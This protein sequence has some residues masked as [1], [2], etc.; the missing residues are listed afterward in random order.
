MNHEWES[1]TNTNHVEFQ[2]EKFTIHFISSTM[3]LKEP[4]LCIKPWMLTICFPLFGL[5]SN[6]GLKWILARLSLHF[7][8]SSLIFLFTRFKIANVKHIWYAFKLHCCS[9]A[10][11]IFSYISFG[12]RYQLLLLSEI[13]LLSLFCTSSISPMS[14]SCA[15]P[16]S[17]IQSSSPVCILS[18]SLL[19]SSSSVCM[20]FIS[21]LCLSSSV[22]MFSMS[23][24]CLSS[25]VYL[26]PISEI[27]LSYLYS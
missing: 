5:G 18:M 25:S 13:Y 12:R 11:I 6:S 4:K 15:S 8:V 14:S 27:G 1:G 9:T 10:L 24:A 3:P 16:M 7:W 22:C 20:M 26:L 17:V 23:L 19:C 2:R 21:L